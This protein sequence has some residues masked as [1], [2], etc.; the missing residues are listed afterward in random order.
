MNFFWPQFENPDSVYSL[1]FGPMWPVFLLE[2]LHLKWLKW[3]LR[4][5]KWQWKKKHIVLTCISIILMNFLIVFSEFCADLSMNFCILFILDWNFFFI[6]KKLI[7]KISWLIFY[8]LITRMEPKAMTR[9][10]I[11]WKIFKWM[12]SSRFKN[13][14]LFNKILMT[15]IIC[16]IYEW[17]LAIEFVWTMNINAF[18]KHF[19]IKFDL[20]EFLNFTMTD[21]WIWSEIMSIW[22]ILMIEKNDII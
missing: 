8:L 17:F 22:S 19:W 13:F 12:K 3:V 18:C 9:I 21:D 6:E 14:L 11:I 4:M 10:Y 1:W 16:W 5:M 2:V 15:M 20:N 7:F